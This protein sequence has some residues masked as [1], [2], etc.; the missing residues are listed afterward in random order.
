LVILESDFEGLGVEFLDLG[1]FLVEIS[2]ESSY[3]AF[4]SLSV[5]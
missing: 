3:I 5:K 2:G 4:G 1:D